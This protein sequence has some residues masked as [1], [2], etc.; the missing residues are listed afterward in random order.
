[1]AVW[2]MLFLL[3]TLFELVE[4]RAHRGGTLSAFTRWATRAE[5][6]AGRMLFTVAWPVFA[7]WFWLHIRRR[8][9][10]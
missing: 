7:A 1:M 9:D 4:V 10:V 8:S 3:G 6:R 5:T 2:A